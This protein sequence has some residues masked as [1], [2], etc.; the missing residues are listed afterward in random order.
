MLA[1]LFI[2]S[3]FSLISCEQKQVTP[4]ASSKNIMTQQSD[5]LTIIQS[6]NGMKSYR[7]YAPLLER[8]E[9]AQEPYMEFRRG[10]KIETFEDTTQNIET[11]FV[12]DYAIFYEN[13]KLWEAKGNVV[14]VNA[15]G[16]IL[17][18]EQLFW[19][20]K[21]KRIYSNVYSTITQKDDVI[22]GEGFESDES[23]EDFIF[24]KPQ[25]RVSLNVEPTKDE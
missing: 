8:Y 19:N 11:T 25:G 12:A 14:S 15:K 22:M 3:A 5:T 4:T 9:L 16:Q 13:Q 2:G 7:F 20:Q 23:M 18:T 21:T 6:E 24:R 1:L 10:I 17:E